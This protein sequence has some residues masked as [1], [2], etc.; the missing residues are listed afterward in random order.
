MAAHIPP[1]RINSANS[2]S[3]FLTKTQQNHSSKAGEGRPPAAASLDQQSANTNSSMNSR[4][5]TTGGSFA[6][7]P[8]GLT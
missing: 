1:M 8:S 2:K 3:K 4:V 6:P 7:S 5:V